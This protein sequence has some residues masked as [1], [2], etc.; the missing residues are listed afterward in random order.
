MAKKK[1]TPKSETKRLD[2]GA[3]STSLP[4]EPIYTFG[5]ISK[6]N[7][8]PNVNEEKILDEK[9]KELN[10]VRKKIPKDGACMFRAVADQVYYSQAMHL[11]GKEAIH[12]SIYSLS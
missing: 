6:E 4:S 12:F 10:L 7:N 11:L 8:N 9:L 2:L 3:I 1:K 5:D